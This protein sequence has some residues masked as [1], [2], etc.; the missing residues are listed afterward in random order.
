MSITI[1]QQPIPE[2]A[3][4]EIGEHLAVYVT[5]NEGLWAKSELN[6]GLVEYA[7]RLNWP[8]LRP[9]DYLLVRVERVAPP[10]VPSV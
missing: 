10:G 8:G 4:G 6:L 9:G 5:P 1:Y 7:I 3:R 2:G